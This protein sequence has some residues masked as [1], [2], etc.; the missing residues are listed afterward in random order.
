MPAARSSST[1]PASSDVARQPGRHHDGR[2][3]AARDRRARRA[4]RRPPAAPPTHRGRRTRA[5]AE[6]ARRAS[7]RRG[8]AAG[9]GARA[10]ARRAAPSR[11]RA[12]S[13]ARARRR[14]RRS[15]SARRARARS[16]R[17]A[18]ATPASAGACDREL[19]RLA[20]V[21]HVPGHLDARRRRAPAGACAASSRHRGRGAP[22]A[23]VA[24]PTAGRVRAA[25]RRR[26]GDREARAPTGRPAARGQSTR[27]IAELLARA[28]RRASGP[29]RRTRRARSGAGR[30]RARPSRRA[31][32]AASPRRRRARCPRAVSSSSR[33]S[34]R[35]E[36]ADRALGRA[37]VE[38]HAARERRVGAEVAEQQVR[39]GDG[40]LRR[41]RARSR[42]ARARRPPSAGPTR[43]APPASAQPML[44]PPAPTVCTST[45]GSW[46][47][48]PAIVCSAA[49]RT[50][51]PSIT[52]TSHDVPPMSNDSTSSCAGQRARRARRRR[53]PRPARRA[54]SMRAWRAASRALVSPPLE[55][56]I[57]GSGR[58]GRGRAL[59]EPL[60]VAAQQRRQVG[61]DH[62]RR[63]ALVL[64]EHAHELVRRRHVHA[65]AAPRSTARAT[66]ALVLGVRVGVQQ[67][68]GDRLDVARR[69]GAR[70]SSASASSSSGAQ[71]RPRASQRSRDARSAAPPGRAAP[72][73]ARHG[74]Y[75][76]GRVWRAISSTSVKPSVVSSAVRAPRSSSSA[77]VAT[78]MPWPKLATSLRLDAG[79]LEHDAARPPS[80]PRT[81]RAGVVGTLPVNTPPSGGEHGVGERAADVDAERPAAR[82]GARRGGGHGAANLTRRAAASRAPGVRG[83]SGPGARRVGPTAA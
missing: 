76:S 17:A 62:G 29:R 22:G 31:A 70:A 36:L 52:A 82:G 4:A 60:E 66:R 65:R 11:S 83:G 30:R 73:R 37:R 78:V 63:R 69:A 19:E 67:A 24:P 72:G 46:S 57:S 53:R 2:L 47:A 59:G 39:V 44:P 33:P 15:R 6:V 42:R 10:A 12:G 54:R 58:P 77:L 14:G 55:R 23:H 50:A 51:P 1:A 45:I 71:R 64:A 27:A 68:D 49:S 61:V 79:A 25:S 35:A 8:V 43:S 21:A 80:R 7:P 40:R 9:A 20:R 75:S 26:L 38:P 18:V 13:R 74:R 3:L 28:G 41:R 5:L 16:A 32:R 48:R 34:C 56:M 81:G